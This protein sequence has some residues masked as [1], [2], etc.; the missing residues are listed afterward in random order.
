V[1]LTPEW[2]AAQDCVVIVT[3]HSVYDCG[4]VLEHAPLVI[5]TRN[6]TRGCTDGNA[7]LVR[8]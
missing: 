8:L 1:E 5:D 7:R 3:N 4:F 2:L 6:A